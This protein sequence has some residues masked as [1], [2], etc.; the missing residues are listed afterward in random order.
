MKSNY[1]CK[2]LADYLQLIKISDYDLA[3]FR[4]SMNVIDDDWGD[5]VKY[6]LERNSSSKSDKYQDRLMWER[7]G[8]QTTDLYSYAL[9]KAHFDTEFHQHKYFYRGQANIDYRDKLAPGIYRKNEKH[10]ENY[11][12]NEMQVRC[13]SVLASLKNINKLT[14]MQHYGCPTR[15]LDI[16]ANPLVAL[17]FACCDHND[18]DTGK[19]GI[20]FIFGVKEDNLLY[21]QSDRV[22]M[23]SKLSEFKLK[24]QEELLIQSYIHLVSGKFP[25]P[26]GR[27]YSNSVIERFYHS[28]KKDNGAFERE[29]VPLD[30]LKPIFVQTNKD[31][32]RILKQDG[33]FVICGL[34]FNETDSNFKLKK[35]VIKEIIIPLNAKKAILEE[36]EQICISQATLFPEV[37]KVADY[38]RKK[39]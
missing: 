19:D 20:I 11:Y 2:T 39:I 10:D 21:E 1:M 38:L 12:Y 31:N 25:N 23:L 37:D 36:L 5:Q 16:T 33:A 8:N 13:P 3:Q 28:V 6:M 29:I 35:H 7:I 17:Y 24:E 32:P 14:Y 26:G 34:D 15:L 9:C 4:K 27:K 18:F 22:Q 30:L